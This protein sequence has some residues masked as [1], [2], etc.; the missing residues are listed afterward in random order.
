MF[1]INL[2]ILNCIIKFNTVDFV[3]GIL[4]ICLRNKNF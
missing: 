1:A 2:N 4:T 3:L